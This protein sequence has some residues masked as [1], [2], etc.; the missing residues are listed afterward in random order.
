KSLLEI[1][2][3][4]LDWDWKAIWDY[5]QLL[6]IPAPRTIFE[7]IKHLRPGYVL[8]FQNGQMKEVQYYNLPKLAREFAKR[9][10]RS[11]RELSEELEYLLQDSGRL[12]LRSDVPVGSLLSGGLDSSIVTAYSAV[13]SENPL[14][15]SSVGF[16]EDTE[17]ELPQARL[18]AEKYK[19]QHHEM[20]IS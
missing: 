15:T 2:E 18:V 4:N 14:H 16:K 20:M 11:E 6:Y 9:K 12:Q 1:P 17:T 13:N 10:P 8:E 5:F 3:I 19:T 7:N